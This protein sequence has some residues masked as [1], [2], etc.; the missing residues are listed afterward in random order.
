MEKD[1]RSAVRLRRQF[2][3]LAGPLAKTRWLLVGT[4][5]PRRI[6]SRRDGSKQWLGPYYQWTF[7]EHGKT[8]TVNLSASQVKAFQRA[9]DENR[10]LETRLS[11]MRLL[12]RHFLE[13]T[14]PSVKRRKPKREYGLRP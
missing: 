11:E 14:T 9:I 2:E 3:R 5:R 10:R 4:I 13:A 7:K 12:S 1:D 6:P 8:V